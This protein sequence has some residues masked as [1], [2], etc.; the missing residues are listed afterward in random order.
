MKYICQGVE[1]VSGS[2]GIG[3]LGGFEF[4]FRFVGSQI[5]GLN[6]SINLTL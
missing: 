5:G 4:G 6:A 2:A 1:S 3:V